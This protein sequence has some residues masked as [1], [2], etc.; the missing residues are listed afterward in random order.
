MHYNDAPKTSS[1]YLVQNEQ[2]SSN[3]LH[4]ILDRKLCLILS[5]LNIA[6]LQPG[7]LLHRVQT[8]PNTLFRLILELVDVFGR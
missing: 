6:H 4:L 7:L 8:G 1:L 2:L 5:G 3:S